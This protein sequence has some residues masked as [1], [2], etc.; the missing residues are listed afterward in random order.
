[1]K[2]ITTSLL[3]VFAGLTFQACNH[4]NGKESET[5]T[6]SDKIP[7]RIISLEQKDIQTPIEASGQFYTDDETLLAFKTG[8]V[9]EKVLVKEGDAIR[10]GQLLATLNLTEID[11]S[12]MQAQL[13]L[14]KAQRDFERVSHLYEDSV[15]TLEQFQNSK[16]AVQ[17]ASTQYEAARFNRSY[18]EI[19]ALSNGYVLK[20]MANAGQVIGPGIPVFQTNGAKRGAWMLK[21]GV[22]DRAWAQISIGDTATISTDATPGRTFHAIVSRKSEGTDPYTGS[23][24]IELTLSD[25]APGAIASG[26]FGKATI[27]PARKQT[28]WA[29]PYDALLDADAKSGYV[30]VT[31]DG[32]T[33]SKVPVLVSSVNRDQVLVTGGLEKA[34]SLII[35]GS[36]YLREGSAIQVIE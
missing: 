35:S 2:T 14:E 36:A 25:K 29:I 23:F 5:P 8:G 11:A 4:S 27:T 33:A 16:T 26:M 34:R 6:T 10:A 31:N 24:A 7:V 17:L 32:V 21:I 1:M 20:K 3:M 22:S 15:A 18:S 30:F 19:R 9:V 13:A 28:A 12:V